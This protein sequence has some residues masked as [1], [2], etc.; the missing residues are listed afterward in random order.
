[1]IIFT[2]APKD[3][4]SEIVDAKI[5][6]KYFSPFSDANFRFRIY[7]D[8]SAQAFTH[9]LLAYS[10]YVFPYLEKLELYIFNSESAC[11]SQSGMAPRILISII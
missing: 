10:L 4:L 5:V 8:A 9:A 6:S 11:A 7:F 3:S 1:M 2:V